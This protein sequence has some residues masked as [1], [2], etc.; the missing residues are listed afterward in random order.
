MDGG[1]A[2]LLFVIIIIL[3]NIYYSLKKANQ[4]LQNI[5]KLLAKIPEKDE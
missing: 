5:E 4:T 3:G 1:A 2:I